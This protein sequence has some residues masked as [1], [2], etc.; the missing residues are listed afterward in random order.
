MHHSP[1]L[2]YADL[3]VILVIVTLATGLISVAGEFFRNW[4][5]KYLKSTITIKYNDKEIT[6]SATQSEAAKAVAEA[7][8]KHKTDEAKEGGSP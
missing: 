6:I 5:R 2:I 3:S 7:V 4:L 1:H 8:E